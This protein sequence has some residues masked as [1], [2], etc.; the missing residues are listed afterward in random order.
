MEQEQALCIEE[1]EYERADQINDELEQMHGIANKC[2]SLIESAQRQ[3]EEHGSMEQTGISN[4]NSN[5]TGAGQGRGQEYLQVMAACFSGWEQELASL[6]SAQEA[7]LE[8][9]SVSQQSRLQQWGG[10]LR[11][12]VDRVKTALS[13]MTRDLEEA[14]KEEEVRASVALYVL[15]GGHACEM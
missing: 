10:E 13:Y 15:G 11:E 9:Y 12:D 14:E 4:S 5:S 2:L 8:S 3:L 7:A 1:E 6:T